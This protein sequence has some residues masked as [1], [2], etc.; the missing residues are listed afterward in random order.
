MR[1]LIIFLAF[2]A[3]IVHPALAQQ[4]GGEPNVIERIDGA[5][6]GFFSR[7][8]KGEEGR[9]GQAAP[10]PLQ[11]P[12]PAV[13]AGPRA[14]RKRPAPV[15]VSGAASRRERSAARAVDR[16]LHGAISKGDYES[17]LKMIEQGADVEA[18]DAESGG[19]VLHFA[20]MKGRLPIIDLLVS[21]GA[22]INSRT[23]AGTTPLQL[24]VGKKTDRGPPQG[25]GR[26]LSRRS[27]QS[28]A[29][30]TR[31]PAL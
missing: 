2:G 23:R 28:L 30:L 19:W 13:D 18:S 1:E 7:Y 24:A 5:V 6:R 4:P 25:A 11:T 9:Q 26:A 16:G 22:D 12:R 17:A 14:A 21:R 8:F 31:L 20:V 10:A 15:N 3:L 29:T 27:Y